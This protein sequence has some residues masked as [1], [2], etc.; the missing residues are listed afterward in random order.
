LAITVAWLSATWVEAS[1]DFIFSNKD[2]ER[3]LAVQAVVAP[4]EQLNELI[5]NTNINVD[6]IKQKTYKVI[7]KDSYIFVRVRNTA[8]KAVWGT[9]SIRI[10]NRKP[11]EIEIPFIGA[12]H[13]EWCHFIIYDGGIIGKEKETPKVVVRWESLYAK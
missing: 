6:G 12:N 3:N 13:P 5:Q 7:G 1:F 8:N 10:E 4:K 2:Y 11:V 9:L